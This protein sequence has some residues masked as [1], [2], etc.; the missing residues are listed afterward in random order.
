MVDDWEQQWEVFEE[1]SRENGVCIEGHNVEE[2]LLPDAAD[3]T[4]NLQARVEMLNADIQSACES[5]NDV[6]TELEQSEEKY[7][8]ILEGQAPFS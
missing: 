7:K 3:R 4:K 8:A 6:K 2:A 1:R 5:A